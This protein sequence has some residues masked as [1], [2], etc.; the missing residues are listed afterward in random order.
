MVKTKTGEE[1][2]ECDIV[3]SAAGIVSNIE[4]LD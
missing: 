1:T 2:I 4:T 3:L